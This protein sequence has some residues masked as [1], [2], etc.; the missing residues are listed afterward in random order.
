MNILNTV[1]IPGMIEEVEQKTLFRIASTISLDNR[2]Q[3]VEFGAFFGRSTYCLAAGLFN[4][5]T[6]NPLLHKVVTYDSFSCS[7]SGEF[8]QHVRGHARASGVEKLL[9]Q[10]DG[11]IDFAPVFEHFL[12]AH[13]SSGTVMRVRAEINDSYPLDGPI[14]LMHVDSPKHWVELHTLA[15]SFFRNFELGPLLSSKIFSTTG[16]RRSSPLLK[17]WFKWACFSMS[18]QLHPQW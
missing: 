7:A 12:A 10:E 2:D 14:A 13:V 4:N 6:F 18:Y 8:A 9:V 3:I 11:W 16:L 1:K 15:E 17:Q 5:P